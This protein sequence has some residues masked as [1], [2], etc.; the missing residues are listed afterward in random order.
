MAL[1]YSLSNAI[2]YTEGWCRMM[3]NHENWEKMMSSND[4]ETV[5]RACNIDRFF[6]PYF[7]GKKKPDDELI[8]EIKRFNQFAVE[9]VG[10]PVLDETV[11][12]L[13]CGMEEIDQYFVDLGRARWYK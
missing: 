8:N 6:S 2:I 10:G 3:M 1:N 11:P 9:K 13:E 12:P 7:Y 4:E 5:R